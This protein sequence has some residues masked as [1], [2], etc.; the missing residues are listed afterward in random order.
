MNK[1]LCNE[2]GPILHSYFER[3]SEQEMIL[4]LSSIIPVPERAKP[5]IS[6]TTPASGT[7]QDQME[8]CKPERPHPGRLPAI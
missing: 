4:S 7:C 6:G 2:A 8:A 5:Y 3:D 1:W